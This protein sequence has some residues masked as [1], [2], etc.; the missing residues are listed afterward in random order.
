MRKL[1]INNLKIL[2]IAELLKK[3]QEDHFKNLRITFANAFEFR[4][5]VVLVFDG[6]LLKTFFKDLKLK[7]AYYEKVS[8]FISNFKIIISILKRL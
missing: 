2:L 5:K 8:L 7:N 4:F 1:K 3:K 6:K